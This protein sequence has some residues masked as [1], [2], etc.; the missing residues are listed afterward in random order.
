MRRAGFTLIEVT[1]AL[2]VTGVVVLLA[3]AAAQ[4]GFATEARTAAHRAHEGRLAVV[5]ATLTDVVRHALEGVR[6]GDEVFALV[7]RAR[8]DGAAADSLRISTR[9]VL[10]PL[11]TSATWTVSL[12][13]SG[14]TLHLVGHP[15]TPSS[16]EA[17][18]VAMQLHEVRAFDAQALGRGLAASWGAAWPER[19][20][21]PDAVAL[22]IVRAGAE[23]ERLVVR[24]SLERAP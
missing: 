5:R 10:A 2:V 13:L 12:W 18:P 8:A 11:G 21:A 4:A 3:Y 23:P 15:L 7:D 9:G 17:P 24:R 1:V 20:Q 22:T 6:G 16:G 19:D 14:D